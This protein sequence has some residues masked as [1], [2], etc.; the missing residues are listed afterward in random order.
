LSKQHV[1]QA[2]TEAVQLGAAVLAFTDHDFRDIRPD[3]EKVNSW[4]DELRSDFPT[5][6]V[7]FATASEV[8]RIFAE[9]Q[10]EIAF[11]VNLEAK[12]LEVRLE[13]GSPFSHQ[14]FL[15]IKT[16]E[17]TYHSDNFDRGARPGEWHYTFDETTFQLSRVAQVGVG[18]TGE[19]ASVHTVVIDT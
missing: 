16:T 14:P 17:D 4:L 5:A 7:R 19:N 15:A 10:P 12:R 9:E 1:R 2:F 6:E 18:M 8:G 3:I 11:S 13:G